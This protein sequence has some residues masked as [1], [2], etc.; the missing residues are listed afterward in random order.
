MNHSQF[1]SVLAVFAVVVVIIVD[2]YADF[3]DE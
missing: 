1:P 2:P 3:G